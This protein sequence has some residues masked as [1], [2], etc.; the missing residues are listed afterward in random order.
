MKGAARSSAQGVGVV[1]LVVAVTTW[2]C[3]DTSVQQV[4]G[5]ELAWKA[6]HAA[7]TE[8]SP[9]GTQ[10]GHRRAH[11]EG[12]ESDLDRPVEELFAAR[13]EHGVRTHECDECRFEVGVVKAPP[14]LFQGG[15][16]RRAEASL[17]RTEASLAVNGEI[18][19]DERLLTHVSPRVD[20]VIRQVFVGLGQRVRK[21]EPLLELE[22]VALGEAQ[23][24]YLEAQAILVLVRRT[25]DWQVGLRKE[26][27][28]SEKEV[29][30]TRMQ[31]E[32]AEIRG[33][34]AGE[35]LVRLGMRPGEVQ[36]L[37]QVGTGT[38]RGA[39]VMRAPAT[40]TV[41]Q[42]HAV[43]GEAA[44]QD[45]SILVLGDLS[46]LWLWA[47]LY[48]RD[49]GVVSRHVAEGKLRAT[50]T[51]KA[52]PGEEFPGS[53]DLV[54]PVMEAATRT[55]RAR[56]GMKNPD[57]KLRP[58]MFASVRIYLPQDAEVVTVPGSAVLEDEGRA[59]VF[60]HHHDAYYVRRPV[61]TGLAWDGW[62]EVREGLSAGT[63]VVTE[64]CFLMK[65][66]L[67]RTKM[68]AGCAD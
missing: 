40:G 57:G 65:S 51:V 63:T 46:S 14:A 31:L 67:L 59:F 3:R 33:R 43:P 56:M 10:E 44:K 30:E 20:G 26:N 25:H 36:A 19:F 29:L 8:D 18:G 41:L 16:M 60:V 9:A 1:A 54:G 5:Q 4:A 23:A 47:D 28:A 17:R 48:E 27:L 55:V 50:V 15:L 62:V 7:H 2:G 32:S 38:A 39:L 58:G 6:E 11:K 53:V 21:D 66:D 35:K 68:G 42:L 37:S 34:S 49:L 61:V 22:S 13:C 45:E 64:G 24:A 52:F 12:P